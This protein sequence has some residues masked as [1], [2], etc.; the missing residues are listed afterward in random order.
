MIKLISQIELHTV[1]EH[2]SRV[3]KIMGV[4][5]DTKK[6]DYPNRTK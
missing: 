4:L 2:M 5:N 6:D 3:H 1:I